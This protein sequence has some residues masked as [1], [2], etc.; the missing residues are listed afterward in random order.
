VCVCARSLTGGP[1]DP[2]R[3]DVS[4]RHWRHASCDRASP[5]CRL[6]VCIYSTHAVGELFK[7]ASFTDRALCAG[8][9]RALSQN[10]QGGLR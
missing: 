10:H 7:S 9:V 5:R 2:H 3:F 1:F 4:G 8:T 6:R